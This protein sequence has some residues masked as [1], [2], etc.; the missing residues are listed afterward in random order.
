MIYKLV[1]ILLPTLIYWGWE[2]QARGDIRVDL[3]LIYPLLF[4]IYNLTLLSSL[5]PRH[6]WFSIF[7]ALVFSSLIM[8]ANVLVF[9]LSCEYLK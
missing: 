8:A 6:R 9:V 7:Y 2:T 1:I 3:I 4:L 5:W